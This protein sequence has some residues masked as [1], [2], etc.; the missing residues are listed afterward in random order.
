MRAFRLLLPLALAL[1]ACQP[2][3]QAPPL[4][5]PVASA[6][7]DDPSTGAATSP[8]PPASLA[9]SAAAA[10]PPPSASPSPSASATPAPDG[11][12]RFAAIGASDVFGLGADD[13][14]TQN[15]AA[16]AAKLLDA[17]VDGPVAIARFGVL[18]RMADD[19]RRFDV[20]RAVATKPQ[21]AALWTGANDIR[22]GVTL[23]DFRADL[24]AILD[25][26]AAADAKV[27]VLNLPD[28]HKLPF[29]A[30]HKEA[31]REVVP[32]WQ[33][34]I[35]AEGQAHG[36]TV[37]DLAAYSAELDAHPEYLWADGFH[38]STVGYARIGAIVAEAIGKDLPAAK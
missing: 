31:Y 28:L 1:A 7:P 8:R 38:P 35:R 2:A 26:L 5:T 30:E 19:M 13:P 17:R 10:S 25:A 37:I 33:A 34:A 32:A 23:E 16:V 20:E 4:L 14:A 6:R 27:Y 11:A 24:D 12:L 21:V 36:A 29:F 3:P 22:T 9:P 18:N 15:W